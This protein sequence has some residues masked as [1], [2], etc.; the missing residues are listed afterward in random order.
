MDLLY[1]RHEAGVGLD[2]LYQDD[3]R[4]RPDRPFVFANMVASADGATALA[5]RAG[6][7]GNETDQELLRFLR[8]QAPLVLVGA[9]TVRAERYGP[10]KVPGQRIAVITRSLD[11]DFSSRLFTSGCGLVVTTEDAGLVPAGVEVVRAGTGAVDLRVALERLGV[12]TVLT[13]GG[14]GIINQLIADGL[15]DELDLTV[16]PMV[17]GGNAK[18]V[19]GGGAPTAPTD[20]QLAHVAHEDGFL[21]LRYLRVTD[22]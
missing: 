1:P 10:S 19:G 9:E 5:G 4:V 22:G 16:S 15:L 2:R 11:L 17:V 14:P 6:G 12:A 13:E 3:R 18:R 8:H 20:L 7:L 21:F